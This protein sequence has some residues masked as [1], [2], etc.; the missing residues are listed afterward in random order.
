MSLDSDRV[1]RLRLGNTLNSDIREVV[2]RNAVEAE[3][4]PRGRSSSLFDVSEDIESGPPNVRFAA[5]QET[6]DIFGETVEVD[7]DRRVR[8]EQRLE[9]VFGQR[10]GVGSVASEDEHIVYVDDTDSD[11]LVSKDGRRGDDLKSDFDTAADKN[12]IGFET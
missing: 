5:E 4:G 9:S 1:V 10:V 7:N 8:C 11:P 12:D 6:T 2:S 3:H